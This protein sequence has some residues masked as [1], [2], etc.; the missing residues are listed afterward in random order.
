MTELFREY[1]NRQNELTSVPSGGKL[2][3]QSG[4]SDPDKIDVSLLGS[5]SKAITNVITFDS[6][7]NHFA[8]VVTIPFEIDLTDAKENAIT[9]L[10]YRG[11]DPNFDNLANL[12]G[13][14][15][16]W[17]AD[18]DL[19]LIFRYLGGKV[20]CE[21]NQL[22]LS[23]QVGGYLFITSPTPRTEVNSG[24][25]IDIEIVSANAT[26]LEV[27]YKNISDVWVSIGQATESNNVWTFTGW[28]PTVN[29]TAI[30]AV[31][32]YSD[33][34]TQEVEN[35]LYSLSIYD[36]F[37][38]ANGTLVTARTPDSDLGNG[39][40]IDSGVWEIQSNSLINNSAD[41]L[42]HVL[43]HDLGYL[44]CIFRFK[45]TAIQTFQAVLRY[46]STDDYVVVF[47]NGAGTTLFIQRVSGVNTT[48]FTLNESAI[49]DDEIQ[50]WVIDNELKFVK[51]N[52]VLVSMVIPTATTFTKY[53]F[54]RGGASNTTRF[55]D[56]KII[57]ISPQPI[58]NSVSYTATKL[59][60]SVIAKGFNAPKDSDQIGDF[61][62]TTVGTTNYL[63]YAARD[64]NGNFQGLC[65]AT[66]DTS[67]PHNWTAQTD[68]VLDYGSQSVAGAAI[69][70][71][72]TT[73]NLLYT[74]RTD[75]KLYHASGSTPNTFTKQG[76]IKDITSD[77]LYIR[78][79]SIFFVD[80]LYFVFSDLRY[81]QPAGE[82]GYIGVC[83]GA[84]LQTLGDYTEVLSNPGYK[85]EAF[86][87]TGVSVRYN[88]TNEYY[89][90]FYSGYKGGDG[91]G[92][93]PHTI[94]L[95]ISK[96]VNGKYQRIQSTPLLA[97][98]TTSF[99]DITVGA[100]CRLPN[101]SILYYQYNGTA[102]A[103]GSDGL[104]YATLT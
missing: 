45:I 92:N 34:S 96:V 72:G 31:A 51:N 38:A 77:G 103:G 59:G 81:D 89:E 39:W 7:R 19:L 42:N 75:G 94:N 23:N 69:Y 99:D 41:A 22:T 61:D 74:D 12:Y 58:D 55:D 11:A 49:V 54:R 70:Y 66:S 82:F 16:S 25:S 97:A 57:P 20:T 95:A 60:S 27:F 9:S 101:T 71:D 48:L 30:K 79:T 8:N 15:G 90:M 84:T 44:D 18:T 62:I 17:A 4:T 32:T 65:L 78:Q 104:T 56:V 53:G 35:N 87:L 47:D 26:S 91:A 98:G 46:D 3:I 80:G 76:L 68:Y 28:T 67:D 5:N 10:I 1:Y 93:F 85:D 73:W 13:Y 86:N 14:T 40:V 43:Y 2:L 64:S 63:H 100:P 102:V 29:A 21:I 37:T 52:E 50:I 88:E 33:A 36:T 83:S 6:I 24:D